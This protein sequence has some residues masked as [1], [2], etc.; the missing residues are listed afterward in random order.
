MLVT[1]SWRSCWQ[2]FRSVLRNDDTRVHDELDDR[3]QEDGR[4][5]RRPS[6]ARTGRS[7]GRAGLAATWIARTTASIRSFG[8]VGGD[9]RDDAGEDRRR[10]QADRQPVARR[11]DEPEDPRDGAGGRADRLAGLGEPAAEVGRALVG[12]IRDVRASRSGRSRGPASPARCGVGSRMPRGM[13]GGPLRLGPRS[14]RPA[15]SREVEAED[16]LAPLD[17]AGLHEPVVQVERLRRA[18]ARRAAREQDARRPAASGGSRRPRR[19]SPGRSRGPGTAG[20]SAAA[21]GSTA[22]RC[23][24]RASSVSCGMPSLI[25]TKPTSSV[26]GV[27]DGPHP[28]AGR[29]RRRSRP[30]SG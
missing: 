29:S 3:E 9:R 22:R 30:R 13:I 14:R 18:V 21:T 12:R 28:R 19:S 25:I 23:R 10:R 24:R 8:D 7:V 4:R 15:E 16:V 20:R 27:V 6:T 26:A 11:P 2:T 17:L 1:R 5:R